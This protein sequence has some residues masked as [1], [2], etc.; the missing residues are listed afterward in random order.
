MKFNLIVLV[1]LFSVNSVGL[2][3]FDKDNDGIADH[4]DQCPETAQIT[5]V[6]SDFTFSAAVNPDRLKPGKHAYPV[7]KKGCEF[8]SDHDGVMNSQDYCPDNTTRELSRGIAM[9]GCPKHSDYD[10]TPDYR[11]QCPDTPSGVK[12]DK[13]GCQIPII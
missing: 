8:D 7:D 1:G 12:T 11:D 9:N 6:S 13:Y 5:K 4:L 3:Y 2:A 10:G